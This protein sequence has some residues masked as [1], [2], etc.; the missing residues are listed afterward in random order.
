MWLPKSEKVQ[1]SDE[2]L[3]QRFR[4]GDESAYVILLQRHQDV[5]VRVCTRLL[6]SRADAQDAAQEIALKLFRALSSFQPEARFST[7]L[8]RI[9]INHCLNVLRSRKRKR[10]LALFGDDRQGKAEALVDADGDPLHEIEKQERIRQVRRALAGLPDE[11]RVAVILHRYEGLSYEEIARATHSSVS[12][13]ES[14]LHRAK[15]NLLASLAD[16]FQNSSK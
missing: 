6:Q 2:E 3:V 11:Q 10:W 8:Y 14:R 7:W 5:I 15:K 4:S 12:A 1:W 16:Y 13:V 9:S